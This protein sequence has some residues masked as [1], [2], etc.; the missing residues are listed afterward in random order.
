MVTIVRSLGSCGLSLVERGL[1][2]LDDANRVLAGLTPDFDDDGALPAQEGGR[3]R[4]LFGVLDLGDVGDANRG[5]SL[6]GDDDLAELRDTL[7]APG[8]PQHDFG[9]TLVDASARNLD[10]VRHDGVAHLAGAEAVRRELLDVQLDVHFA[11]ASAGHGDLADA[12]DRFERASDALVGDLSQRAEALRS[13]ERDGE[14]RL[15]IRDPPWR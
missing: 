11:Q 6:V 14:D 8:R 12:V 15:R 7:E 4:F 5:A 1:D 13:T 10:V 3:S 9:V 2:V